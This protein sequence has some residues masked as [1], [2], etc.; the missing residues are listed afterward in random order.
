M[1]FAS[2]VASAGRLQP[3]RFS[4]TLTVPPKRPRQYRVPAR[5]VQRAL[6]NPASLSLP[7]HASHAAASSILH[8]AS[9]VVADSHE[10]LAKPEVRIFKTILISTTATAL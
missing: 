6:R 2:A 3:Y 7:I 5:I 10:S 8:S 9:C 1:A 4:T